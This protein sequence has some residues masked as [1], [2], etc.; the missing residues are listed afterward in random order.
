MVWICLSQKFL[1][2]LNNFVL[3][4]RL[5]LKIAMSLTLW[6]LRTIFARQIFRLNHAP[7]NENLQGGF[8]LWLVMPLHP[9][10]NV[11]KQLLKVS[12]SP[13]QIMKSRIFQKKRTKHVLS[14]FRSIFERINN[15]NLLSRFTDLYGQHFIW[16]DY[17]SAHMEAF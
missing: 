1:S 7:W 2:S 11:I 5:E 3:F 13:K 10:K 12:K 14:D 17:S 9:E 15:N 16:D 8:I 6:I 4:F